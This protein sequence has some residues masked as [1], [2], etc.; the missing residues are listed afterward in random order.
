MRFSR[1]FCFH[2]TRIALSTSV[3]WGSNDIDVH[4]IDDHDAES[5]I[6]F[7]KFNSLCSLSS[8]SSSSSSSSDE[9]S[10]FIFILSLFIVLI[11]IFVFLVVFVVFERRFYFFVKIFKSWRMII[12]VIIDSDNTRFKKISRLPLM[13]HLL[14]HETKNTT[15]F[16]NTCQSPPLFPFKPRKIICFNVSF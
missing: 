4:R 9:S 11:A 15:L 10:V 12:E 14:I 13:I 1:N 5:E 7:A 3:P 8:S 2:K 16:F 6:D